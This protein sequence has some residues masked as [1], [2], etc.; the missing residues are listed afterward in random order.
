MTVNYLFYSYF[1]FSGGKGKNIF[2]I[3]LIFLQKNV[4]KNFFSKSEVKKRKKIF[5]S[6]KNRIFVFSKKY[7]F[8]N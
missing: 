7:C 4:E 6:K 2:P 1:L 8:V 3:K 5:F